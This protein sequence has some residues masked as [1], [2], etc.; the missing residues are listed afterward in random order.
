VTVLSCSKEKLD[1]HTRPRISLQSEIA[2]ERKLTQDLGYLCRDK[3]SEDEE[4]S[5]CE[6]LQGHIS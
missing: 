2:S 6:A 3:E 4:T 5:N 1:N